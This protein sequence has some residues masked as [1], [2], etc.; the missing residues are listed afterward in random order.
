MESGFLVTPTQCMQTSRVG[1]IVISRRGTFEGEGGVAVA[2]LIFF[3][4]L[5]VARQQEVL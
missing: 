3:F 4:F 1:G 2:T 5:A